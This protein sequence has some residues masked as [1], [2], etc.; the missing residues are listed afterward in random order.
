MKRIAVYL[1]FVFITLQLSAQHFP[2]VVNDTAYTIC[3]VPVT[4]NVLQNDYDLEGDSIQI[5]GCYG[6]SQWGERYYSD[7]TIIFTPYNNTG[8]AILTYQ[9]CK[10]NFPDYEG[11]GN[12]V[13]Y[14][15]ENPDI[16]VAVDDYATALVLDTIE[17]KPLLNDFDLNNES[18]RI[19]DVDEEISF[20]QWY[21]FND[22]IIWY[23]PRHNDGNID[24][25][26]YE[27][28]QTGE[29]G[30]Y[31]QKAEIIIQVDSNPILPIANPDTIVTYDQVPTLV[32]PLLNDVAPSGEEIYLKYV[33][34]NSS[35]IERTD[36][37]LLFYFEP[38]YHYSNSWTYRAAIKTNPD[39][40]SNNSSVV[41]DVIDNPNKPVANPDTLY[42][43][44]QVTELINPLYN[45]TDPNNLPIKLK[46][47]SYGGTIL[48]DSTLD[49]KSNEKGVDKIAYSIIQIEGDSLISDLSEIVIKVEENPDL[50]VAIDDSVSAFGGDTILI[51][52]LKNDFDPNGKA[53]KIRDVY[54][55][56]SGN[57][58]AF[59]DSVIIYTPKLSYT[60]N[61]K[62]TYSMMH[63]DSLY[64]S[65]DA[66]VFVTLL[67]N[68]DLP[69]ANDDYFEVMPGV[70]YHLNL[71]ENDIDPLGDSLMLD[72]D[73]WYCDPVDDSSVYFKVELDLLGSFRW[74]NQTRFDYFV[75]K[76]NNPE[77]YS[78]AKVTLKL[79]E[80]P[81]WPLAV[82]DLGQTTGGIP[83]RINVLENDINPEGFPL[84]VEIARTSYN[85]HTFN[86]DTAVVLVPQNNFYGTDTIF[87]ACRESNS[88][89]HSAYGMIILDVDEL[90][91]Y[92]ELSVNNI[93][94]GFNSF[95]YNFTKINYR[96]Y[97]VTNRR[98]YPQF[99][100]PKGSGLN[101]IF[102]SSFWMGGYDEEGGLHLSA[103]TYHQAGEDFWAGPV[104]P[105]YDSIEYEL[106]WRK[107]WKLNRSEIEDHQDI[108]QT[109][110]YSPASDINNW[111]AGLDFLDI[112]GNSY[113]PY[114]DV[115]KN[116]NYDPAFGDYPLIKG[117]EALFY[118]FN[119]DKYEHT[120]SGG[121]KTGVEIHAMPYAF[122]CPE[123]S[124]FDN[125]IFV[126]YKII[127]HSENTYTDFYVGKSVD[128]DL[129]NPWDDYIGCDTNLNLFFIYNGDDF[130]DDFEIY[131]PR[132]PGYGY[133]PPSTGVK[134]LNRKLNV[135][136]RSYFNYPTYW[137]WWSPENY[138]NVLSGFWKHGETV[139]Y[140]GYG[141]GGLI[142]TKF[143]Y[144]DDP[145]DNAG[146]SEPAIW[147]NPG[148][149]RAIGSV[150]PFTF[151]PGD[152]IE[153]ELAYI[154]ARDYEGDNISSVALLKE[155]AQTIQEY[156]D[157]GISPCGSSWTVPDYKQDDFTELKLFPNPAREEVVIIYEASS[158]S[159]DLKVYDI[160]GKIV[161]SGNLQNN[162]KHQISIKQLSSGLYLFVV[163]DGENTITKKLIKQPY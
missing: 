34:S 114:S 76:K 42:T 2:V 50:P 102:C 9:V 109:L 43:I 69:I 101:S 162:I 88:F 72:D 3:Q 17:I 163:Q 25:L 81:E 35:L 53:L 57:Q 130:D 6:S 103:E 22:S 147:N 133:F 87:Y 159:A 100:A 71:L 83:V 31:S 59:N 120:E 54:K 48:N 40:Y 60:G 41:I 10:T 79:I 27:I 77:A 16:P 20:Y 36:S 84:V 46:Y 21:D 151:N 148:D 157:L 144:P 52:V 106:K 116:G 78:R 105:E 118:I 107:I 74:N 137:D 14:I 95:G 145:S 154:F 7:S 37:T 140:G 1:L 55:P 93:S 28:I 112:N 136:N 19:L 97:M 153:L 68:P 94:A 51:P 155:R 123:D 38:D 49:Y 65:H 135:F 85:T 61:I 141:H 132:Q 113:A 134:I 158:E 12:L 86:E 89:Q 18:F 80:N 75:Q 152:T 26:S 91:S 122:Y 11:E 150:G 67:K 127:N 99:E 146:W 92:Q 47:V 13:I 44:E 33:M 70:E 115:N 149:R 32:F 160:T 119:D 111:P 30:L 117:D 125:T 66:S 124:A 90:N 110:H 121:E 39:L 64:Y 131:E 139:T 129:G 161:Y 143:F 96:P 98:Y 128:F 56:F 63:Q 82:D 58:L 62:I 24:T 108:W 8:E 4:V 23:S 156:Y 29:N 142:P 138:Y 5:C 15:D 73:Q 45:D 126:D 104:L